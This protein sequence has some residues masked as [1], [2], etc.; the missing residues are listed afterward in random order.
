MRITICTLFPEM[1]E[2]FLQ[3]SIIKKAQLQDYVVIDTV[4]IRDFT[5]DKHNRVD[6]YPFGGGAGL[7]MKVQPIADM[8]QQVVTPTSKVVYLTPVAPVMNQIKAKQ[9]SHVEHLVLLCG[10]YEGVDERVLDYVDEVLS[11]GDYI[12]TGGEVAAMVVTDAVVRLIKGVISENS[13]EVESFEDSLLEYPQYTRPAD[14][15]GLKVPDI[16]LSGH[17]QNI[18]SWQQKEAIRK[19]YLHRKDLLKKATLNKQQLKM[20]EEV[21]DEESK[22]H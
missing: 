8:L 13:I 20:L 16:L 10:H 3:T 18:A 1:F 12:L 11:I 9:L 22:N 15:K 7:V 6:D 5:D 21:I 19:T 17:H 14:Y 4:N 2:N